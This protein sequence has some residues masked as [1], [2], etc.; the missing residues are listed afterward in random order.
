MQPS[1]VRGDLRVDQN[2]DEE[3]CTDIILL[4]DLNLHLDGDTRSSVNDPTITTKIQRQL[5]MPAK[6]ASLSEH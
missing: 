5:W 6:R 1:A 3:Q 2:M 4:I